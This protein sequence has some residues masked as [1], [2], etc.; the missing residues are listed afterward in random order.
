LK[1]PDTSANPP[2]P[3]IEPTLAALERALKEA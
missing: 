1:Q 2:L 3:L